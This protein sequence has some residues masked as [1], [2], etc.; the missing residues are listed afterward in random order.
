MLEIALEIC[1]CPS[2]IKDDALLVPKEEAVAS[3][4]KLRDSILYG[5][6]V[7]DGRLDWRKSVYSIN[8]HRVVGEA[9]DILEETIISWMKWFQELTTMYSSANVWNM[10]ES[11]CFFNLLPNKGHR[12][13]TVDFY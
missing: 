10:D 6:N 2:G 4:E 13:K 8:E 9:E 7:S 11:D 12:T 3:K 5:F 1:H